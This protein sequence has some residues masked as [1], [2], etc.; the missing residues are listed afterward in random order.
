MHSLLS[1]SLNLGAF[2]DKEYI[3]LEESY[4]GDHDMVNL[5][6]SHFKVLGIDILDVTYARVGNAVVFESISTDASITVCRIAKGER[7]AMEALR[8]DYESD[9]KGEALDVYRAI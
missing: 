1:L 5:V 8:S 7:D 6:E 3:V 4:T 9:L 2:P